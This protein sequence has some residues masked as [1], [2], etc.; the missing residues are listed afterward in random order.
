M[1]SVQIFHNCIEKNLNFP[2]CPI[3]QCG[4]ELVNWED[5]NGNGKL[6]VFDITSQ[7]FHVSPVMSKSV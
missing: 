5:N 3:F 2:S 6:V 1:S 4:N 7:K